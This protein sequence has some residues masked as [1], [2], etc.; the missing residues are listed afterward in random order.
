MISRSLF[1]CEEKGTNDDAAINEVLNK[2]AELNP[3][4]EFW[5]MYTTMRSKVASWNH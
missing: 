2:F 3:T 5:K 1:Y 4:Y